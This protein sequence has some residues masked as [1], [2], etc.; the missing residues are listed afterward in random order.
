MRSEI[1]Q[2]ISAAGILPEPGAID[3]IERA[4]APDHALAAVLA[5]FSVLAILVSGRSPQT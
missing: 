3:A 5:A 4:P 2:R 1:V